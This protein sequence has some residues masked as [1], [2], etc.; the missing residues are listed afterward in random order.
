MKAHCLALCLVA[1]AAPDEARS[2]RWSFE[3]AKAGNIAG[4][5]LKPCPRDRGQG[6]REPVQII[7]FARDY[8]L[9]AMGVGVGAASAADGDGPR[10]VGQ[11]RTQT[12]SATH[13]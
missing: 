3:D 7:L 11:Q 12:Y 2:V 4:L 6:S 8:F 10:S 13:L 1:I 5:A 9:G